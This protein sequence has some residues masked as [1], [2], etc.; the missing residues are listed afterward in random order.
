MLG[1]LLH[2]DPHTRGPFA[3]ALP[4]G[5]LAPPRPPSRPAPHDLCLTQT[6][7]MMVQGPSESAIPLLQLPHFDQDLLKRLGRKQVR[8]LPDLFLMQ[9]EDRRDVY[10][11]AGQ[12][13]CSLSS[14]LVFLASWFL[15]VLSA[16]FCEVL[17][18]HLHGGVSPYL[19]AQDVLEHPGERTSCTVLEQAGNIHPSTGTIDLESNC[20]S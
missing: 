1:S 12:P 14:L 7:V 17:H 6:Y 10:A 8:A 5:P 19:M 3:R 13:G 18:A 11:F 15:L 9:P 4:L 2:F 20:G 16:L